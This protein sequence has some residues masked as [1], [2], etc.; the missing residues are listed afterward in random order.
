MS[1]EYFLAL[2]YQC[3]LTHADLEFLTIGMCLDYCEQYLEMRKPPKQKK[4][5]ASQSHFDAF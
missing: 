3:K 1:T 5:N 4:V 2:C